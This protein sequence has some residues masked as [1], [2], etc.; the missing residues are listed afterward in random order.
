MFEGMGK[1]RPLGGAYHMFTHILKHVFHELSG[2]GIL[3]LQSECPEHPTGLLEREAAVCCS[4]HAPSSFFMQKEVGVS[5]LPPRP[6]KPACLP[7]SLVKR[8]LQDYN[9]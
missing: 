5:T 3:A 6:V 7:Q 8:K 2:V 9:K 1:D 4:A